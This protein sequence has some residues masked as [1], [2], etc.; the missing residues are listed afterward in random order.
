M[1]RVKHNLEDIEV[2]EN[3]RFMELYCY[4]MAVL[5]L[6]GQEQARCGSTGAL[7]LKTW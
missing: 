2:P 6:E 1:H 4:E 3:V 7:M 5:F